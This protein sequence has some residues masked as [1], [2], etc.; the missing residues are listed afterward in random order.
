MRHTEKLSS[1]TRVLL[2]GAGNLW[3]HRSKDIIYAQGAAANTIFYINE[4]MVALAVSTKNR[5]VVVAV[6]GAGSFFNEICLLDHSHCTSTASAITPSSILSIERDE[7]SRLLR[8]RNSV[9]TFLVSRL[10]SSNLR[11]CEDLV[12]AL[13]NS[14]EQRLAR[15]L[16]HLARLNAKDRRKL[17]KI[18]QQVL[19]EMIAPL[20]PR[21]VCL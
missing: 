10:L 15:L 2:E 3:Q 13:T 9:S 1:S 7:V 5:R 20:A 21:P 19:A 6:L 14:I 4:G 17:P 8:E 16:L 18:T 12:S 11:C